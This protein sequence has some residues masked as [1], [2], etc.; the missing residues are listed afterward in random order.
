MSNPLGCT[1]LTSVVTLENISVVSS[2]ICVVT[3]NL[4]KSENLIFFQQLSKSCKHKII[5][6][7][8]QDCQVRIISGRASQL[9]C[10]LPTVYEHLVLP[11]AGARHPERHLNHQHLNTCSCVTSITMQDKYHEHFYSQCVVQIL[12]LKYEH[13]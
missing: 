8:Y 5:K 6:A 7:D 2:V 10:I 4:Q 3:G 12:F 13:I 1:S 9:V 11:P